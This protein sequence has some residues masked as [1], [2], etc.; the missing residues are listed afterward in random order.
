MNTYY[1]Y[2][3]IRPDTNEVFYIGIGSYQKKW[4][5]SRAH[6][7]K[8]RNI[9]WK[10]I[11]TKCD[12]IFEIKI[13]FDKLTKEQVIKKEINFIKLYG[14]SDLKQGLLCNLTDGGEGVFN[15][16][17]ES[18]KKIGDANRGINNAN[19]G[20]THSQEWKDNMSKR[21]TGE[22]NHNYG[23][24]LPKWQAELNRKRQLGNK[25]SKET[26]EL[27]VSQFRKKVINTTTG[28]MYPSIKE[29]SIAFSKSSCQMTRDIN[30]NKYNLNFI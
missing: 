11:V 20:K 8:N 2:Q 3:H 25:Q 28:Y 27:R 21:L 6:T 26:I 30:N 15:L 1:I 12:N 18:K 5:Y 14:R 10:R 17:Y 4:K 22:G 29:V 23:K 7:T 9:H 13:L 19:F 16:S 24:P